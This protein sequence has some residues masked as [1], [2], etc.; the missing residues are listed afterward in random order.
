[1][2]ESVD[3]PCVVD[4]FYVTGKPIPGG[5]VR[6]SPAQARQI[7]RVLRMGVGSRVLTFNGTGREWEVEIVTAS[8]RQVVG[9]V[10]AERSLTRESPLRVVLLQGLLK[11]PKMDFLIQK[12][13]EMG[14]AEV[15]LLTT[16]R[17]V[18]EGS[19]K[20]A[21]WERIAIEAA[22]QSGRL[23]LP[24]ITGP[25]PLEGYVAGP[26]S[27]TA[28]V[29]WEGERVGTLGAL[30]D[31]MPPPGEVRIVVGPEGGLEL[32]EVAL[33]TRA[34]FVPVSLG[35]RTLRAETA[36]VAALAILQYRWGDL[37]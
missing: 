11:G 31:Q 9:R 12:A 20:V 8:P 14:V 37:R 34:G 15:V 10:V 36:A 17:T 1:M 3:G 5:D 13:T 35:P 22:E 29:L 30:L 28:L 6:F 26:G 7:T 25:H 21:R 2:A 24:R 16:R 23:T 18:A 19:G 32:D 33:L 27:G 4:R